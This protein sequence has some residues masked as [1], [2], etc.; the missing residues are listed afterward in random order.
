MRLG[1]TTTLSHAAS[2]RIISCGR[3]AAA[4]A[5]PLHGPRAHGSPRALCCSPQ[6]SCTLHLSTRYV[7]PARPP[8]PHATTDLAPVRAR[9][10]VLSGAGRVNPLDSPDSHPESY[11]I[12]PCF[13]SVQF[14]RQ[15]G[16]DCDCTRIFPYECLKKCTVRTV[17]CCA[18]YGLHAPRV[19]I[20]HSCMCIGTNAT[21]KFTAC[22]SVPAAGAGV[23]ARD[24]RPSTHNTAR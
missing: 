12:P 21:R 13:R 5:R 18:C 17:N 24:R 6:R 9:P 3:A 15:S 19:R 16:I 1:A 14:L 22:G 23:R 20:L 10:P 11:C 7:Q 4:R 8:I 2:A